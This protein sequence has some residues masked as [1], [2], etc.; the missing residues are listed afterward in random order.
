[1]PATERFGLQRKIIA[2]MTSAGWRHAA[3]VSFLYEADITR[4]LET[5]KEINKGRS[6]GSAITFNTAMMKIVV[7]GVRA[8]PKMNGHIRYNELLTRGRVTTFENIDVTMPVMIDENTMMTVNLR[9]MGRKSIGEIRDAVADTIRRARSSH[10]QQ[11]MYEVAMSDTM[12]ELK[13]LHIFKALGRL[14]GFWL[15]GGGKTLLHGAEKRRYK[16]IPE[17]ER[18]TVRDL[19]QGT[20]TITNP[21]MLFKRWNGVCAVLEIVPPQIAAV[22]INMPRN[23]AV[24][25]RDGTIRAAKSV[26]LT[27]VFDHRALDGADL[28][29]FV[30]RVDQIMS[31]PETLKEFL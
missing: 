8:C 21:G 10:L 7:E 1:M 20:I 27:I 24:V 25:D 12:K 30:R 13:R 17:T 11:A 15:D 3:H 16:A 18:L 4:L 31:A 22:A 29:P 5:L 9:D 2:A 28:V 26:E 14:I 19:E 23:K 6:I